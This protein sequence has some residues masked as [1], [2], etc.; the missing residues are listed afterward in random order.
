MNKFIRLTKLTTLGAFISG[1]AS[2]VLG[3][4]AIYGL[5]NSTK[6]AKNSENR[7]ACLNDARTES[8]IRQCDLTFGYY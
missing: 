5:N 3:G 2:I 1:C 7:A 6:N 8:Q 4:L